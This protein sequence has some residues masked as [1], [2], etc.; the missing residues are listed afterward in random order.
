MDVKSIFNGI[1][2]DVLNV[3][4][5]LKNPLILGACTFALMILIPAYVFAKPMRRFTS[6]A[7]GAAALVLILTLAF[8][9]P[10]MPLPTADDPTLDNS[11]GIGSVLANYLMVIARFLVFLLAFYYILKLI[12][13]VIHVHRQHL[14]NSILWAKFRMAGGQLLSPIWFWFC[15]GLSFTFLYFAPSIQSLD[16]LETLFNQRATD[17]AK[18]MDLSLIKNV[19]DIAIV[20]SQ[21]GKNGVLPTFKELLDKA[22]AEAN[23]NLERKCNDSSEKQDEHCIYEALDLL[24]KHNCFKYECIQDVLN[25]ASDDYAYNISKFYGPLDVSNISTWLVH[26]IAFI[27]GLVT[28]IAVYYLGNSTSEIYDIRVVADYANQFAFAV[29]LTVYLVNYILKR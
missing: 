16:Q 25:K 21:L 11:N 9:G 12:G 5:Q 10:S 19:N 8:N 7:I 15:C 3:S 28:V 4:A 18:T 26:G 27:S 13:Q 1:F 29:I 14:I 2:N 22:K 20:K 17:F 6:N 23:T 24:R